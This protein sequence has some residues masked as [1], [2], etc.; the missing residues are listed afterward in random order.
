MSSA[1]K[2]AGLLRAFQWTIAQRC[3]HASHWIPSCS[4]YVASQQISPYSGILTGATYTLLI[5]ARSSL[6]NAYPFL[7]G[8]SCNNTTCVLILSLLVLTRR[9]CIISLPE[10]GM[11]G[12]FA[13]P[14]SQ[15]LRPLL[16]PIALDGHRS[17]VLPSLPK[18][19]G[20]RCRGRQE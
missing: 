3:T 11:H 1:V 7:S 5:S 19:A 15:E 10:F 8:A 16:W 17:F 6:T 20:A 2:L 9:S 4:N 18:P 14:A 12:E 13:C